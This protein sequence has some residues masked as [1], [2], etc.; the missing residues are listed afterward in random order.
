MIDLAVWFAQFNSWAMS[1]VETWGYLG[2]FFVSL[3]GNASIILPVP[4]Y[5]IVLVFGGILNPWLVGIAA[6]L[7]ATFGELTGYALGRGGKHVIEKKHQK[8]LN[9][10]KKWSE[11]HGLFPLLVLFAATPLP[12]D[13]VGILGGVVSYNIKKFFAATLIGKLIA[14]TALAWAGFFG[15]YLLGEGGTLFSMVIA[16]LF[17]AVAFKFVTGEINEKKKKK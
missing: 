11:K 7:G 14:Y 3:I 4:S 16:V 15:G 5:L 8:L 10:T 9:K 17:V 6:G 12:D 2:I 1:T 13:I